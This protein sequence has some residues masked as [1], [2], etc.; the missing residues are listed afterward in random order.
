M[1][2]RLLRFRHFSIRV[3]VMLL[4]L[5]IAILATIYVR[6]SRFNEANASAHAE[7]R[8]ELAARV[9]DEATQQRIEALANNA[10]IMSNDAALMHAVQPP[11][12]EQ[13]S[14]L[15]EG[16][17]RRI[18]APVIALFDV[19]GALLANS[20]AGMANE[21]EGPFQY[22][23][24]NATRAH[25]EQDSGLSYLDAALHV[26]VVVPLYAPH[27]K[28][29]GWFGLTFPV[30]ATFVQKIK[31]ASLVEMTFVSL[32][33]PAK[34]R[35]LVTTL[36][37]R[38]AAAVAR[39]AVHPM[40][41][42][43]T[44]MVDLPD[45]RYV[46]LF[47]LQ[48]LLGEDPIRLALQRPLEPELAGAR[49]LEAYLVWTAAVALIFAVFVALW[50]ARDV[51][52]PVRQLAAHTRHVAAGRYDQRL[53]LRRD[54]ELGQLATAFNAMSAGLA[55]RDQV[56]DLLD[57][58]VSPEVAAQ[59]MRDGAALGGELRE[60]T[61]LF[62]D[63]RGF[64][65]LSEKLTAPELVA[66]LN[67]YLDRMSAAIEAHGGIIDKFIG[68]A[69]MALF[70]APV[71][72]DDAA[73]RAVAAAL[74]MEKALVTLNAELAAEGRPPLAIGVGINTARVVA[75]N[76]GSHRRLNYSVIGDGVNVAARLQA[77]TRT[78]EYRTNLITSAATLAAIKEPKE[79]S[80]RPLGSV[81]V[82]G[83]A[84]PVEIFAVE[85]Q[86]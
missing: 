14:A 67:R 81:Q 34:P 31:A 72:L 86:G 42:V 79:F 63:L 71:A 58:N 77:L 27:P 83:R 75:G 78:P 11:A 74:A 52:H 47:K 9:L 44:A 10:R 26:L 2:L 12:P 25:M 3:L 8:L 60:V 85:P 64:T 41:S 37:A 84:E 17:T 30:D 69:I 20:R 46:T 51:S 43:A 76:I 65:T 70:G 53:D 6:V 15:L 19:D 23:I 55:E 4:G 7:A 62:A 57:K 48:D 54:D 13:L 32:E 16:Y 45:E 5:L 1:T 61:I 35:V 36:P 68:D 49:E 80:S 40:A 50:I 29:V 73:D 22:L 39:A 33:D 21:N 24:R 18:G 82:K 59:L 66:L 28:I 56:R 38:S